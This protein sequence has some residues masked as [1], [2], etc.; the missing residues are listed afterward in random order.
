MMFQFVYDLKICTV[1]VGYIV[2]F[3]IIYHM[4]PSII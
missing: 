3:T 4:D 2:I 1:A